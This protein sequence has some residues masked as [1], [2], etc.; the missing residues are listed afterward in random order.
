MHKK[1]I[2]AAALCAA[3]VMFTQQ[4]AFCA[5]VLKYDYDNGRIIVSGQETGKKRVSV[6]VVNSNADLIDENTGAYD[7]YFAYVGY[8]DCDENGNY[9]INIKPGD[10]GAGET[11][12]KLRI[13]GN[14]YEKDF[15]FTDSGKVNEILNAVNSASDAA[16][17]AEELKEYSRLLGLNTYVLFDN[18]TA[19]DKLQLAKKLIDGA[20]VNCTQFA[21]TVNGVMLPAALRNAASES[22][23]GAILKDYADLLPINYEIPYYKSLS[24][25]SKQRVVG[26]MY[27]EKGRAASLDDVKRLYEEGVVLE[28]VGSVGQKSQVGEIIDYFN[29][30]FTKY[31]AYDALSSDKKTAIW[32]SAIDADKSTF[33]AFENLFNQWVV[34]GV[35]TPTP[36]PGGSGGSGSGSGS[37]SGGGSWS[38]GG[39]NSGGVFPVAEV[40]QPFTDIASAAWAS[41][42]IAALYERKIVSGTGEGKFSPQNSVKR[43]EF[44]RMISLALKLDESAADKGFAD[45]EN[46]AWYTPC[47]NAAA[48]AGII[49]GIS[50]NMFGVGMNISRQDMAVI[51]AKCLEYEQY[52]LPDGKSAE[53]SDAE[54]ISDYAKNAVAQLTALGVL[55]GFEDSTFRP[56]EYV[57][58]A[59]AAVVVYR[60]I[61]LTEG[62]RW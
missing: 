41:D 60:L 37:G 1:R 47:I 45:A 4:T 23:F 7:N 29:H 54:D 5:A 55:S 13:N 14:E 61:L 59:Q 50:E 8:A 25:T 57:S 18:V 53:F 32:E 52:S 49:S 11:A 46:G 38:G 58:R 34:S 39:T 2:K 48:D 33:A 56:K 15:S 28:A 20:D 30:L 21:D 22:D 17:L 19:A 10:T 12:Y 35:P 31:S 6:Q 51:V 62:K 26:R 24:D 36:N 44:V 27:A 40:K 42:S 3:A 16:V 9:A 43:E